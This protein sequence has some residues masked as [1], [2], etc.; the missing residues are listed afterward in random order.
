VEVVN[1]RAIEQPVGEAWLFPGQLVVLIGVQKDEGI[2]S[3]LDGLGAI[4]PGA[5]EHFAESV[6]GVGKVP[7]HGAALLWLPST[8]KSSQSSLIRLSNAL[9][10]LNDV[11][12]SSEKS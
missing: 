12:G 3:A 5:V 8:I 2:A 10:L 7:V 6:L 11:M 4:A 1:A 9:G